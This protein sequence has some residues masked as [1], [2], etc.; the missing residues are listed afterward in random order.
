MILLSPVGWICFPQWPDYTLQKAFGEETSVQS[1]GA[2]V[3][4]SYSLI[5][6]SNLTEILTA[7]G[8]LYNLSPFPLYILSIA[9]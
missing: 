7:L 1:F 6:T 8:S 9:P 4:G 3:F 5:Y 2:L